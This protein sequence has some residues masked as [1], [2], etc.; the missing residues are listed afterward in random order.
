VGS[1]MDSVRAAV[2]G[3]L[4]ESA[5]ALDQKD[6]AAYVN[7]FTEDA[8][9]EV[10]GRVLRGRADIARRFTERE[11]ERTTR[12]LYSGLRL[13]GLGDGVWAAESVWLTFAGDGTPPIERI[14]PYQVADFRDVITQDGRTWRIRARVIRSVF[15][16]PNLAP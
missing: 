10:G 13:A 1:G 11:G 9:Y 6:Y 16:E 7:F 14:D 4:A 5:W 3:L 12:H 15:R 2:D 8:T